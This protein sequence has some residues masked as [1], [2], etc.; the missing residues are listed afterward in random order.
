MT[1]DCR[2]AGAAIVASMGGEASSG[3]EI[4]TTPKT[5]GCALYRAGLGPQP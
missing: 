4:A 5:I 1:I 2:H 3:A